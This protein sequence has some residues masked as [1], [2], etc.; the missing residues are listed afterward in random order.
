MAALTN[1][2]FGM[3]ARFC[4]SFWKY[5]G[6]GSMKT[7]L[8]WLYFAR[9]TRKGSFGLSIVLAPICTEPTLV[10]NQAASISTFSCGITHS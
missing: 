8:C 4:F 5:A 10:L 2:V 3:L 7:F 1:V 6:I 9:W